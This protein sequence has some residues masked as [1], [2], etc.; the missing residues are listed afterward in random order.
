MSLD[1]GLPIYL[2]CLIGFGLIGSLAG[3]FVA[4]AIIK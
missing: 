4:Q 1:K 3:H 2:G